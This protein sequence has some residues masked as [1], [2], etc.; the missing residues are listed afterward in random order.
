MAFW[1]FLN[2]DKEEKYID[3]ERSRAK[4]LNVYLN[5]F[6]TGISNDRFSEEE[7]LS[8]PVANACLA[9]IVNS[10]KSLPVELYE[11]IDEKTTK[12]LTDDYRIKLLNDSPNLISTGIDKKKLL[13]ILFYMVIHI[14]RLRET[15]MILSRY[16][17]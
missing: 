8:I 5:G 15:V 1:D 12:K 16:G 6:V 14:L 4:N 13:K 11:R 2:N 9:I 7:V 17:I 3:E 10:I